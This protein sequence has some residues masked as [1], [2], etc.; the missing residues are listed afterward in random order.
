MKVGDNTEIELRHKLNRVYERL[1]ELRQNC[2]PFQ[3][4]AKRL[5]LECITEVTSIEEVMF[6][7]ADTSERPETA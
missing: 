6:D 2:F 4:N 7:G 1:E 3:E 5:V